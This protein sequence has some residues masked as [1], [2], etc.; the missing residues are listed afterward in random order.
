[1]SIGIEGDPAQLRRARDSNVSVVHA[2]REGGVVGGFTLR[3]PVVR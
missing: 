3:A 1:M 2:A